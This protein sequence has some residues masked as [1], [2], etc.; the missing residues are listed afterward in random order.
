MIL[1]NYFNLK[2]F[3]S[4]LVCLTT[5][6]IIFY[7][8]SLLGYLGEDLPFFSIL[9]LSLLNSFQ[10]VSIIP[11]M[12]I[13][14]SIISFVMSL[15]SRNELMIFK[16]YL[17]TN[18]LVIIFIPF[19]LIFTAI[20][21]NK[22]YFS[23][24]LE[25]SKS[26]FINNSDYTKTK[27][28]I[29]ESL[30]SKTYTILKG[31]DLDNSLIEEFHKYRIENDNIIGGEY[32]NKIDIINNM[33]VSHNFTKYENN[34]IKNIRDKNIILSNL[35]KIIGKKLLFNETIDN[36][37]LNF[38]RTLLTKIL[39]FVL[40]YNCLFLILFNKKLIDRKQNYFFS[41]L[42]TFVLFFYSMI[43]NVIEVSVY[44]FEFKLLALILML[45]TFYNFYKY[46]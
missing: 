42:I 33:L 26:S 25:S 35:N 8:F 21:I 40:F 28:I 15:R 41:V 36:N 4:F 3:I 24:L 31:V 32:G 22:D 7:I 16:E 9:Y 18:K 17:S 43:I 12:I 27:V 34:Q 19:S 23:N 37:Y 10:I 44:N 5:C 45:L 11:S 14:L 30:E 39:F 2:F 1:F 38:S 46:E 6:I 13:L 20:E 29:H